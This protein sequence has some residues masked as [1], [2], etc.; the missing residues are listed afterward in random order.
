MRLRV[1]TGQEIER[2]LP[3]PEAI[4]VVGRAYVEVS[5]GR[6]E[7]PPRASLPTPG[8]VSLVMPAHLPELG[9]LGLK[10][11]SIYP[12][13]PARGLP[14]VHALALLLDPATGEPLALLNG[15]RLTAL[16]TGAG[17]G[18]ATQALAPPGAKILAVLGAG[19]QAWDQ[20]RAVMAVRPI[21]EARVFT[22]S[23]ESA[24]RLAARV[25]GAWPGVRAWAAAS[26]GEALEGAE[27][28]C[29]ATTS[30]EP[31]FAPAELTPGAHVNGV[32]SFTPEMRE[33]PVEGLLARP[34]GLGVFVDSLDMAWL[35]AGELIAAREAGALAADAPVE[36]GRVLAGEAPGRASPG[37]T[38]FFKSVGLAAQDAA[39]GLAAY[40]RA[41][42]LGLGGVLEI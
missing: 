8:G 18:A 6:A 41:G 19:G 1:L 16:R 42:E 25:A 38:T 5:R 10:L 30:R 12:G 20:V 28:V 3:M 23:G 34:G 13:N 32:G 4:A 26:P 15:A 33:V 7:A 37:Q 24:R 9:A 40:A 36:I 21:A 11:I 2:A 22:P 35:E 31:V 14:T 17:S 27:V 29:C 39:A